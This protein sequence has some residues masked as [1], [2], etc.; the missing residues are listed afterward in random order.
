VTFKQAPDG[1]LA[2]VLQFSSQQE[3]WTWFRDPSAFKLDAEKQHFML[4]GRPLQLLAGTGTFT[5]LMEGG[6][7]YTWGDPRYRSLAREIADAPAERPTLVDALGG[8][9]IVKIAAGGWV[10]AAVSEDGAGY[11]WGTGSPG[12]GDEKA[13]EPLRGD[14]D[15]MLVELEDEGEVLDVIDIGVGEGYLLVVVEG[16]RLFGVGANRNGQVGLGDGSPEFVEDW[17]EI[18]SGLGFRHV[19]C[20]PKA[21]FVFRDSESIP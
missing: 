2:H 5:L 9:K 12:G 11:I 15:V 4:P 3:F 7:V 17:T 13:I 1:K 20:G 14:G 8:L 6:E 19:V 21:S 16:G 10:G 18:P